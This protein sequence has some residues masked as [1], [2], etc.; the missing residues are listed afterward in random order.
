MHFKTFEVQ[1][2][3]LSKQIQMSNILVVGGSRGIGE[4]LI[5][6]LLPDHKVIN[7]SRTAPSIVHEN[8][9]HHSF[10]ALIDEIPVFED[11]QS[12]VYC[13]G[14]INL[15]P[16]TSLKPE[17]FIKDFEINVLGAVKVIQ[18]YA[19]KLKKQ[20]NASVVLFST[21][22]V[23]QGMP[24]HASVAAAKGG[25]EGLT[26]SLAAEFAGSVRFNCVAPTM[27]KTSLAAGILKNEE[28]EQRIAQRHPSKQINEA[29]DVAALV[30]FLLSS[31]SK[32]ITG[33][34]LGIDGGMSTLKP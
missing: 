5:N 17:D 28:A 34:I 27:T 22:A 21:V 16:I 11:V 6:A 26:K 33:Q 31:S 30:Q 4:A 2:C 3:F 24:F 23:K 8:L 15:K 9:Q 13:P 7:L 14:S 29:E 10:D 20:D 25:I 32:N 12:I 18:K 19:R 1:K